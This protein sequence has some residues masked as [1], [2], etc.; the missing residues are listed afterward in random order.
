MNMPLVLLNRRRR[1]TGFNPASLFGLNEQGVWYDPSDVANLAWRRNLLTYSEQFDNAAWVKQQAAVTANAGTAPDGTLTADR[2]VSSGGASIRVVGQT[3]SLPATSHVISV[4]VKAA[5]AGNRKFRLVANQALGSAVGTASSV[6]EATDDWQ[7]VSFTA[8]GGSGYW[9]ITQATSPDFDFDILIWGA[10]LELGSVATDYQ[11]ITDV[12]TEVIERFPTATLY[13]DTIGTIPV[14]TPGQ[15]VALMLDKSRGLALG[16]ELV[17]NGDFSNGFTG[18]TA[19][20]TG[21]REVVGGAGKFTITGASYTNTTSVS[22]VVGRT[23]LITLDM[24]GFSA[25]GA[26]QDKA[27][28]QMLGA[29]SNFIYGST[30]QSSFRFVFTAASTTLQLNIDVANSGAWGSVGDYVIADN[31]SVRELAGNHATQATITSRPTYSIEPVGGRRN[32]LTYSEDFRN[33]ATAGE[34]RPWAYSSGTTVGGD[35]I[36]FPTS[37]SYI[38]ALASFSVAAGQAVTISFEA[39]SGTASTLS[40]GLN[41]VSNGANNIPGAVRSLTSTWTRYSATFTGLGADSG[42]YVFFGNNGFTSQAVGSVELR[43]AQLELGS[44]ATPYQK[45]TTQYDVTEAGV[46]SCSYLF[47]DGGSDAMATSTIT[48]GIDKAQVFAGVRKLNDAALD[49]LLET[50]L[51]VTSASYPGSL[52][53]FAPSGAGSASYQALFRGTVGRNFETI[54]PFA[55]P[56][57]NVLSFLLSNQLPAA[58]DAIQSRANGVEI[59]ATESSNITTAGNFLA[60]PLYLG[61]RQATG[62]FFEG[63]LFGLI[64]RFGAA[65][66][67]TNIN[68]T[69]Y[70]L[71]NKTGAF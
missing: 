3:F 59:T 68:A 57:T 23:Y 65:L 53:V 63:Q 50:G 60:Y 26:R 32:L 58:G 54:T 8:T 33:T 71:N 36:T 35:T 42:L 18:F 25:A 19:S 17:T 66:A 55:A 15:A 20:G 6:F 47:F 39:R 4:W 49:V 9:G 40:T 16:T 62:L 11:R 44:T 56:V 10:Q 1:G 70:W 45:V 14:T 61:G 27:R 13:Q 28:V 12:N 52:A 64:V 29:V 24:T 69:E 5:A 34:T 37:A 31:I 46:P 43:N 7:R 22:V 51:D 48:P 38:F 67:S 2:A 30:S 41:G 21:T